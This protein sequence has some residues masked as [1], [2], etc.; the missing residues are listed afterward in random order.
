MIQLY[1]EREI[2]LSNL[3]KFSAQKYFPLSSLLMCGI[4]VLWILTGCSPAMPAPSAPAQETETRNTPA[5]APAQEEPI[6]PTAGVGP[7]PEILE[8]RTIE[9]EWPETLRLGIRM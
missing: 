6:Q 3:M 5:P 4:V 7:L 8:D 9:M 2:R 1:S